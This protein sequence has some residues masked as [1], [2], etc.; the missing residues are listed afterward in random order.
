MA[1]GG[2]TGENQMGNGIM[3][4]KPSDL[5]TTQ[6]NVDPR[7]ITMEALAAAVTT[8]EAAGYVYRGGPRWVRADG[9]QEAADGK[10]S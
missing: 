1:A 5:N 8:L 4:D 9:G 2:G 3:T 10:Q 6:P 7:H